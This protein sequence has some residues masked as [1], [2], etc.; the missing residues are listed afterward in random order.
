[1]IA[2]VPPDG[3]DDEP[4][5]GVREPLVVS[6]VWT[7]IVPPVVTSRRHLVDRLT[8]D[9]VGSRVG[10][11]AVPI[12]QRGAN[13]KAVEAARNY[14]RAP[15]VRSR[16]TP[17]AIATAGRRTGG[18][19]VLLRSRIRSSGCSGHRPGRVGS[20]FCVG[21]GGAG[22]CVRWRPQG[23][24]NPCYRRER[25]MSWASRRWGPSP[26]HDRESKHNSLIKLVEPG[27]IEPPTSCMPW[28]VRCL[29]LPNYT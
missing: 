21:I 16:P 17:S 11:G 22:G 7:E 5:I 29:S 2:M 18:G 20:G 23:D 19:G 3:R 27:G 12:A 13:K 10:N 28:N 24:S 26:K 14:S 1:L 6:I 4:L 15:R 8:A 25:A 9:G